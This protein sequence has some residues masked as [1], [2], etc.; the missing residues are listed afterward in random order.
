M[1]LI[2][3]LVC[4]FLSICIVSCACAFVAIE[5]QV[6]PQTLRNAITIL[7]CS[8]SYACF[9]QCMDSYVYVKNIFRFILNTCSAFADVEAF[10][11]RSQ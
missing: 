6:S 9:W 2:L 7:K 8:D 1:V 3:G 4:M 5:N 10:S 11:F